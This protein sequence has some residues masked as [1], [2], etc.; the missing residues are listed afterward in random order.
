MSRDVLGEFEQTVLLAILQADGDPYAV[1]IVE[2]IERRTGRP[3]S[4][5]AV[6][7]TLRRLEK[8]G[9]ISSWLGDSTPERGG[10]PRRHVKVEEEGLS[11]LRQARRMIDSMWRG[12][13]PTLED[14]S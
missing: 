14:V 5:S 8:K 11:E 13:D 12:L 1:P 10:K 9:L 2:E 7:V 6:Y 3:V 4:R